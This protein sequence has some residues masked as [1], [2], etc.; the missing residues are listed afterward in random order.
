MIDYSQEGKHD[1]D[2]A[3]AG[4]KFANF[5]VGIFQYVRRAGGKGLKRSAVKYRVRG[6]SSRADH[7]YERAKEVCRL[8]DNGGDMGKKSETIG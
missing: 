4:Y 1:F 7:I 5:S 3:C 2:G 8:L 6:P